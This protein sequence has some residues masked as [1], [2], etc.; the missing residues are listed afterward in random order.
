MTGNI[1]LFEDQF[2]DDMRPITLTR[3]AFAVTCATYS[4]YDVATRAAGRL[5]YVVR[6][7]LTKV[8]V[9]AFPQAPPAGG[10]VMFLN[11]SVVPDIR[12]ADRLRGLLE[13]GEPFLC[14][15]GQR[16]TAALLPPGQP[17][18]ADL[19]PH[20]VG[21]WL[22][23]MNLP[24]RREEPFA[25]FDY[26]FHVIKALGELFPS[27]IERRLKEGQYREVRP[28]VFAGQGVQLAQ[29]AAL[30]P[31]EGPIVLEDGV[32]VLDFAYLRG[33]L[34]VGPRSRIIERATLK[35]FT[36][37][38]HT[39]KIGGEVEASVIEPHTNKQH[40]GFLGHAYVGSWVNLGAGTSNS[41]LKNTY[42]EVRVEHNGR[43]LDTGMQFLGC[44]LGDYV[45]SA[46][47][48]SIFT[49]KVVG[50]GSMLYGFVGQ[51]VPSFCNYARSFG[52]VTECPL[53]Q[54]VITQRRM[55]ARRNVL[56]T[57]DDIELLGRVFELTREE[58]RITSEPPVL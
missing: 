48:T 16:V 37:V 47:N 52:Q 41:D 17:V 31:E 29:T 5:S 12:Y 1:V 15:R 22:L 50:V 49:G 19:A 54:A 53:E 9:R 43:R 33:P 34:Y 25:T 18:P 36:A 58:R 24:L 35:E 26:P 45:K 27:A 46:I 21:P 55:F 6:D 44:I 14:T 39:C 2:V 7:Y 4:L 38:G 20:S 3:P 28:G 51:N 57:E 32:S 11:A 40:H 42:G 13:A 56:Q 30:H 10:P 8:A 23:Q